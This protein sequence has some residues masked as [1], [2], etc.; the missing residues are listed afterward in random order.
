MAVAKARRQRPT[1]KGGVCRETGNIFGSVG[2]HSVEAV[3]VDTP[4]IQVEP[5]VRAGV[6]RETTD[7]S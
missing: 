5:R 7:R 4:I 2:R 3:S 6:D 1:Y